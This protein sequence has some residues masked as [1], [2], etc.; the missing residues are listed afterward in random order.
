MQLIAAVIG[1]RNRLRMQEQSSQTQFFC[2]CIDFRVS[3]A[4]IASNRVSHVQCVN[5]NLV[6]SAG[7]RLA[8]QQTEF[9]ECPRQA[10]LGFRSLAPITDNNMP[11]TIA[12]MIDVKRRVYALIPQLPIADDQ[13]K[14]VFADDSVAKFFMHLA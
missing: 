10:K 6:S 1:K 2:F 8:L 9:A 12:A 14:V 13:G 7:D 5:A 11:F 4:L 3:I